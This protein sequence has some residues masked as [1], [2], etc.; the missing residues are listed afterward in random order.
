M[1]DGWMIFG[2]SDQFSQ[3]LILRQGRG[4]AQ[5]RI[6]PFR[7]FS[8]LFVPFRPFSCHDGVRGK[9]PLSGALLAL[10]I[11]LPRESMTRAM[12]R[13][14]LF[15]ITSFYHHRLPPCPPISHQAG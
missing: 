3:F 15:F 8:S 10:L 13:F 4:G 1:A 11:G 6:G 12:I 5:S 14:S 2:P 7:P 9:R